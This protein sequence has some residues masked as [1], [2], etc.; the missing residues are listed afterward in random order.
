MM[1]FKFNLKS[2]NFVIVKAS[3]VEA[4]KE[5]FK[6]VW[7]KE[8]VKVAEK[9]DDMDDMPDGAVEILMAA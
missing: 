4:A 2:T 9:G 6:S 8:K 7:P 3:T 1:W 5:K